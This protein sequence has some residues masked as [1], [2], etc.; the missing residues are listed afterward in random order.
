MKGYRSMWDIELSRT[1]VWKK[2]RSV[3]D[4]SERQ[5]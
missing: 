2:Y 4:Y 5:P 1:Q 3:K